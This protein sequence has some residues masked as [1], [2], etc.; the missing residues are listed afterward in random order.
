MLPPGQQKNATELDGEGWMDP[1]S[2]KKRRKTKA[3]QNQKGKE[4]AIIEPR[5]G[6]T[7]Q[8]CLP[9]GESG[10]FPKNFPMDGE[11]TQ[12][13]LFQ[14]LKVLLQQAGLGQ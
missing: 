4:G 14:T 11:P 5:A 2:R 6:E 3:S 9:N 13:I 12:Q 8:P 10:Q 7:T 1:S